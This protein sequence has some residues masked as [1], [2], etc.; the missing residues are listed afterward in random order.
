MAYGDKFKLEIADNLGIVWTVLIQEDGYASTITTLNGSGNPLSFEFYG[1]D[2]LFDQNIMGSKAVIGV[3]YSSSFLYAELFTSENLEYKV[4][5]KQGSTVFWNGWIL[6]NNYQEPYNC[7]PYPVSLVATDGLGLLSDF[8]FED[9]GYSSRQT[10]SQVIYDILSLVGVTTFTEF[11]NVFE[12]TMD[13]SVD[14]SPFD[15]CG[16]DPDLFKNEDC[17]KALTEILKSFGAGIRQDQGVFI[18]Y[19]FDE[20]KH[21]S[22]KGR[23]FTSG[24]A[25]SSTTR[26]PLQYINRTA[27]SSNF[28][29]YD[30]GTITMQPQLKKLYANQDYGFKK[31]IL[32][33]YNFPYDEFS[34]VT[35]HFEI[36]G[37]TQIGSG[38]IQPISVTDANLVG[39]KR[40]PNGEKEGCLL[41]N[42]SDA[43]LD[44]GYYQTI[45]G[46]IQSTDKLVIEIEVGMKSFDGNADT[47]RWYVSVESTDGS[48]VQYYDSG[49]LDWVALEDYIYHDESI[50]DAIQWKTYTYTIEEMP[51]TGDVTV[52]IWEALEE[53][54]AN[55]LVGFRNILIY[56]ADAYGVAPEGIGYT[57]DNNIAGQTIEK[58]YLIGDGYGLDNDHLQ[59]LGALNVYDGSDVIPSSKSWETVTAGSGNGE[60]DTLIELISQELADQYARPKQLVDIPLR[61]MDD[62]TFLMLIGRI[63]D[64]SNQTGGNNRTFAP[65]HATFDV[66][67]REWNLTMVELI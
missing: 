47:A 61:E 62:E 26:A 17:Y 9:L 48:Y 41:T 30:G 22:M 32:K 60:D 6:A 35:D 12:S 50:N 65:C 2:T 1:D 4:I 40:D 51:Y 37:W 29:D 56:W 36:D 49:T 16:I 28:W 31:S 46:V 45:S 20:L 14:D 21:T 7:P 27:Q 52:K 42:R 19:R 18:I 23:I 43:T 54:S 63:E 24:T 33:N 39:V 5:I 67:P 25:K 55:A 8:R 64:T 57:I 58:E 11:V 66:K 13:Q 44:D 3:N 53:D 15:Q 38:Y 59:Y 34:Y 10:V